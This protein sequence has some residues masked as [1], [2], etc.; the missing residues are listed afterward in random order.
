MGAVRQKEPEPSQQHPPS[1]IANDARPAVVSPALIVAD[2]QDEKFTEA[3]G[4]FRSYMQPR[5]R[6]R[7][8]VAGPL[9]CRYATEG[10]PVQCGRAWSAE[11]LRA[12]VEKG[13]H[14]SVE[15]PDA[16]I[17]FRREVEEKQ[18]LKFCRIV[19]WKDIK[20][21]PPR[22]LKVSPIAAVPHKSRGYRAILDLSFSLRIGNYVLPSVN[23]S[24][25]MLAP[26]AV[27]DQM[28]EALPRLIAALA[29]APENGG[30]VVFSKLDIKDGY[31]RMS[32]QPG[33]EWNFAYVLPAL[34]GEDPEDK[35]LA[36]PSALQMGWAE[37]PAFFFAASE[38]ARDVAADRCEEPLGSLP[39]HPLEKFIMP[40]KE[41]AENYLPQRK[42]SLFRLLEV[43]VDDFCALAQTRDRDELQHI[44]RA[45]LHSIHE[46]FPPPEVTGFGGGDSVSMKKLIQGEGLWATCKELLG[47][48]FDGVT[49]CLELP[50]GKIEKISTT[51]TQ[52]V[53]QRGIRFKAYQKLLGKVR[54]A[55]M[56][57]PGSSG[58]F[59]PLN[60]VLKQQ[61]GWIS[62]KKCTAVQDALVDFRTL[63]QVSAKEPTHSKELVPGKPHFLGHCDACIQGAGGVWHSGVDDLW[64]AV[65][66]IPWP[67]EVQDNFVSSTNREGT[68]SISDLECAG[69]LLHYLVLEHITPLRHKHVGAYCDN[70]PTVSWTAKM[71][72][73][74]SSIGG[75]LVRAL[76][77]R[78]RMTRSSPLVAVS[79]AGVDN[80]MA[81]VSSRSFKLKGNAWGCATDDDFLHL[82]NRLFPLPQK[83]CWQM[84]Q[85]ST[86]ISSRVISEL[87]GKKLTLASW[88]RLPRSGGSIGAIGRN[89]RVCWESVHGYPPHQSHSKGGLLRCAPSLAGSGRV[90]TAEKAV[91]QFKPLQ[92]RF[93]PSARRVKWCEGITLPTAHPDSTLHR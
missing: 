21:R 27:L 58:L 22:Q 63:L 42:P 18:A 56:G 89:T 61:R 19:K 79:I 2:E 52:A 15:V 35:L 91:S 84:F 74:R 77:L 23:E 25:R 76:A 70:T 41:W 62:F 93:E 16:A 72:S 13:P 55:A 31:W 69:L 37:S 50:E 3:E 30:D 4:E 66:R 10:C 86:A 40:P 48:V 28:G 87:T 45:L 60:M 68:I 14:R 65:W 9:L 12:A 11:E 36:I 75:R 6:A 54:H 53:R 44:T 8:H 5:G 20:D 81:D 32:V 59:T 26:A 82:F 51:I 39:P 67:K 47:W 85:L 64:P 34:Q 90:I 43:Y 29:K 73:K 88:M 7:T 24:S 49:R 83:H 38:T 71:A 57:V 17:Q 1:L 92:S 46:V 33:A 78:Q 80:D